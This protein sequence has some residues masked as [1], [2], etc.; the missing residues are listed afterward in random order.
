MTVDNV[1]EDFYDDV[2][3]LVKIFAIS[4]TCTREKK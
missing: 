2:E 4:S 1:I 3:E